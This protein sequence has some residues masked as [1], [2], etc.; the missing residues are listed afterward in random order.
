MGATGQTEVRFFYFLLLGAWLVVK[1]RIFS[2]H[3]VRKSRIVLLTF[4]PLNVLRKAYTR[5]SSAGRRIGCM[6]RQH[7]FSLR[8]S[9][10]SRYRWAAFKENFM[11]EENK[12]CETCAY[13]DDWTHVCFNPESKNRAD[14]TDNENTCDCW[15]NREDNNDK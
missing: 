14:F 5:N 1:V 7:S 3:S 9:R 15:T 12:C 2:S 4:S 8:R 6:L 10:P 13:H 11:V